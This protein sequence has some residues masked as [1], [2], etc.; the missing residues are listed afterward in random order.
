MSRF[1]V[2]IFLT[3]FLSMFTCSVMLSDSQP[4]IFTHS[5]KKLCNVFFSSADAGRPDLSSS[6]TLSLHSEK[7]SPTCKLLFSS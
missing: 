4:T 3:V 5:L 2:R 1:S 6:V 7:D